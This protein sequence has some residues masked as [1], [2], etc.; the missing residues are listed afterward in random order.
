MVPPQLEYR[1]RCDRKLEVPEQL[2]PILESGEDISLHCE[3]C[4]W[5]A[6]VEAG[7]ITDYIPPL[8]GIRRTDG[9]NL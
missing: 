4:N 2:K 8:L 6:I 5:L 1:C 9:Y 7:R 3:E